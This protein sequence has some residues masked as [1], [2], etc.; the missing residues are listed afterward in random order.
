M[1]IEE[2]CRKYNITDYTIN[3]DGSIDVNDHGVFFNGYGLNELPL[4][5]NRVSGKFDCSHNNL[6]SLEGC[7]KYVGGSFF[8]NNNKLTFNSSRCFIST[9]F[10][11]SKI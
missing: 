8:C 6:T 9:E 3:S 1:S 11:S 5:F 7:P 2:I 10:S 4:K